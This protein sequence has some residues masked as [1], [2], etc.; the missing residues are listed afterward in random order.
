VAHEFARTTEDVL[1]RRSRLLFLNARRAAQLVP[2]MAQA[3]YQLGLKSD[4]SAKILELAS[5][6]QHC[7]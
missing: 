6:Y 2:A 3:A 1:A 4:D 7:P 5:Q